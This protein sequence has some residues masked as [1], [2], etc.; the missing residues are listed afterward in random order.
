MDNICFYV[1]LPFSDKKRV[2]NAGISL[3]KL[4]AQE[5][6]GENA[7]L[8][9]AFGENGKPY[10]KHYPSF[11][12]NISHSENILAVAFSD[13]PVGIDVEKIRDVNL[14]IAQKYF[15]EEEKKLAHNND[16]FFYVWTR[17]EAYIKQSGKGLSVP[18]SSFCSLENENIKTFKFDRFVISICGETEDFTIKEILI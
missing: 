14:K 17:K 11:N 6:F 7:D 5:I 3:V 1:I 13:S 16:D 9:V 8:E 10:F 18:L 2:S 12:F 4:K 15:S